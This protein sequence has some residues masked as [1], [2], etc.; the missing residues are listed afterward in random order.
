MENRKPSAPKSCDS[1]STP[2][3]RLRD[4]K[5]VPVPSPA[6]NPPPSLPPGWPALHYFGFDLPVPGRSNNFKD[7]VCKPIQIVARNQPWPCHPPLIPKPHC[8]QTSSIP[9]IRNPRGF[10]L[11]RKR[12]PSR[13]IWPKQQLPRGTRLPRSRLHDAAESGKFVRNTMVCNAICRRNNET[14]INLHCIETYWKMYIV[15]IFREA[16]G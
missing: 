1:H 7:N 5:K 15:T 8:S 9:T 10:K 12:L 16:K 14:S 11:F 13:E 3:K 6:I 4:D 2:E